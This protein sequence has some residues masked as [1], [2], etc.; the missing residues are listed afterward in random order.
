ML[1]YI[2]KLIV[3]VGLVGLSN[4]GTKQMKFDK[5]KWNKEIDGFYEYRENMINDLID[6]QL[7]KGMTYCQLTNM[8][9]E[10]TNYANLDSNTIA[11]LIMEDYGWD[12]DPVETK[13]LRIELT[14]DSL[15][16]NF[17]LVHRKK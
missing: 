2:Y 12:I 13:I 3:L 10:P 15:I 16:N 4:C 6:N 17:K 11:Y 7:S 1:K 5:Q 8:I 9:G 14:K